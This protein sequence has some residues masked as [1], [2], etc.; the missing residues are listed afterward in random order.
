MSLVALSL[1]FASLISSLNLHNMW[2][3]SRSSY[4]DMGIDAKECIVVTKL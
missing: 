4:T 3:T 2:F 1:A